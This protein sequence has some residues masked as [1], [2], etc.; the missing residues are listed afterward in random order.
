MLMFLFEDR[1]F[2]C[3]WFGGLFKFYFCDLVSIN[4]V[5]KMKCKIE[6]SFIIDLYVIVWCFMYF[7]SL[8][9]FFFKINMFIL[10]FICFFRLVMYMDIRLDFLKLYI[11]VVV[12][13][14]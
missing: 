13:W 8:V 1:I 6:L 11:C 12:V 7:F 2:L 3:N 5:N 10:L 14:L 4:V 9:G